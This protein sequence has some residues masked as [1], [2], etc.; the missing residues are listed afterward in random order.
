[1]EVEGVFTVELNHSGPDA[2]DFGCTFAICEG[3]M[4]DRIV[5]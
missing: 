5:A 1:M 2:L 3:H 4:G